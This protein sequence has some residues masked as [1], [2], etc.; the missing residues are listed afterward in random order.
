MAAREKSS[1]PE[2]P[3]RLT[4]F[5]TASPERRELACG[6]KASRE[7][8][9]MGFA[10]TCHELGDTGVFNQ[11]ILNDHAVVLDAT[12]EVDGQHNLNRCAPLCR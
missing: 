7:I 6:I 3:L 2:G 11:A 10:V 12:L 1:A 5:S 9:E 8:A 4:V